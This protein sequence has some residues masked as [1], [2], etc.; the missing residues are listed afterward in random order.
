MASPAVVVDYPHV[1]K[2]PGV[3]GGK[4]RIE[5]TRI[6]VV[7]IVVLHQQGLRPQDML[8]YYS[9]RPLTLA[10]VHAALGYY[11]DHREEIES[12]FEASERAAAKLEADRADYL[13][14]KPA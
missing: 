1:V 3:R 13:R 9:S 14:H 5:G 12:Y 10:E 7:D 11:Y 8:E 4:A 2:T 6:C